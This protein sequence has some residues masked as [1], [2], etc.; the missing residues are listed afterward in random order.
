MPSFFSLPYDIRQIIY[1]HALVVGTIAPYQRACAALKDSHSFNPFTELSD[2][3]YRAPDWQ[4]PISPELPNTNLLKTCRL[5]HAEA[6]PTLYSKNVWVLPPTAWTAKFFESALYNDERRAWVK[7]V[8]LYLQAQDISAEER[9]TV[10]ADTL[11]GYPGD[12]PW[13]K[14]EDL[15]TNAYR[16]YLRTVSWPRKASFILEYLALDSLTVDIRWSSCLHGS[17]STI[18]AFADGFKYGVPTH[19]DISSEEGYYKHV[20]AIVLQRWT[21]QRKETFIPLSRGFRENEDMV[22]NIGRDIAWERTIRG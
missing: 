9:E 12:L 3:E 5:I 13:H 4:V 21:E 1:N 22:K 20:A 15:S 17:V 14:V 16:K 6:S 18:A 19:F 10:A 8:Y 2:P 11:K 7:H